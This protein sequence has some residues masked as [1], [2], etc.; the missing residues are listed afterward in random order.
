VFPIGFVPHRN[1][2]H[3]AR[4]GQLAGA[5]LRPGLVRE[6]IAHPQ[7]KL[8]NRKHYRTIT[9]SFVARL[10]EE[11]N[12]LFNMTKQWICGNSKFFWR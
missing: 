1:Y 5:Q 3:T 6:T 2:C 11:P 4:L 10:S 9:L 8:R 12:G 7:G